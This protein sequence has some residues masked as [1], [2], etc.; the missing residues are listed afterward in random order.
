M[1]GETRPTTEA[2]LK[3]LRLFWT[4]IRSV[5]VITLLT[6]TTADVAVLVQVEPLLW[7]E[8][9]INNG[10]DHYDHDQS[11][12]DTRESLHWRLLSLETR[13]A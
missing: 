2:L 10:L 8:G 11:H 4:G 7:L 1:G 13:R 6:H 3:E 5:I 9:A 12:Y